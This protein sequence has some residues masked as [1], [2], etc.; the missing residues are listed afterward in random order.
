MVDLDYMNS[1]INKLNQKV[2]EKLRRNIE[3]IDT[4][5][6]LV[7]VALGI[8][9]L[10]SYHF[11][12]G[13]V[14]IQIQSYGIIGL[15]IASAFLEFVPQFLNPFL[16]ILVGI[17]SGLN[18]DISIIVV[19]LGSIFGSVLGFELGKI[20]G[21]RLISPLLSEKNLNKLLGFWQKHGKIVVLISALT[22][23]PYV[24]LVFGSLEMKRKDFWIYGIVP[25][26]LSF[27][28]VGYGYYFGLFQ[29]NL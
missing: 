22:P 12:E 23:L 2:N 15:F 14:T 26:I 3:I 21:N 20:Y 6:A 9:S 13:A 10:L 8:I 7:I 17:A 19:I 11:F 1:Y 18:A 25:R 27:A 16:V 24:P 5:L 29:Y 28:I 4:L